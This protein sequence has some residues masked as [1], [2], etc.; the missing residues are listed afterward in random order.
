MKARP[1][2]MEKWANLLLDDE[3]AGNVVKLRAGVLS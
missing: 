1:L 3:H 2:I